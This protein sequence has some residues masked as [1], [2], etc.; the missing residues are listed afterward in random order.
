LTDDP[1]MGVLGDY[2]GPT[3]T[4]PLMDGSPAIDA[5]NN[6][7]ALQTD[8]RGPGFQRVAGAGADIGAF[9]V[10]GSDVIFADGFDPP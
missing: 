4:I 2:G 9:E 7:A 8:Q 10:Q 5:G 1:L 6:V 3:Q